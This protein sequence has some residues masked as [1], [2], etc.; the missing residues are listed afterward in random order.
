M[1]LAS[2]YPATDSVRKF[3]RNE[4]IEDFSSLVWT[5]RYDKNGD[6][7]LI[8]NNINEVLTKLPLPGPFDPPCMVAIRDS[9]VPMIVE[10]HLIE[11]PKNAP[12]KITTTGRTFETFLEERQTL[13]LYDSTVARTPV[14]IA[15]NKP[16]DAALILMSEIIGGADVIPAIPTVAEDRIPEIILNSTVLEANPVPTTATQTKYP[17]DP[18]NLY[19]WVMD[20]LKLGTP[21][22]NFPT[23][24]NIRGPAALKS[25]L[26]VV[27]GTQIAITIYEGTDRRQSVVFDAKEDQF[28]E[29]KHLLSIVGYKNVMA[30]YAANGVKN[31]QTRAAAIS[32]LSRRVGF[33]DLS[34]EVTAVSTNADW[35]PYLVNKSK[36]ALA[37]SLPT[38]LFSGEIA[39]QQAARFGVDY[40]LGDQVK[41]SG[42]Y[43]LTQDVRIAEF[44]R[45]QDSTGTKSYPTFEAITPW[46][47]S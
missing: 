37:G 31:A 45:S 7:Q 32:G 12:P 30:T 23:F 40:F 35:A 26:P 5:E 39:E 15:A 13:G 20:T 14:V 18:K 10:S 46:A 42:D 17:V 3:Q 11:E 22:T 33:Q 36:I 4:L 8:S 1:E 43:G 21:D 19:A 25:T 24:G 9:S 29:L 2:L 6:F 47:T 27:G 34:S 38:L 16:A 44:V 28:D 41:L